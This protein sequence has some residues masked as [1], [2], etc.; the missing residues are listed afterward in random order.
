M[1]YDVYKSLNLLTEPAF[2]VTRDLLYA[3]DTAL[4]S[5]SQ[6]NLQ[7]LVNAVVREGAKYGLELNWEKTFQ[8]N[9]GIAES[10]YRPDGSVL[11]QKDSLIYLGGLIAANSRVSSELN[12]RLSEGRAIFNILRQFWSHVNLS[13]DRKLVVFNACVTSKVMYALDSAWL[14]KVDRSRLDAFQCACL[15]RILKIPHSY[16]SRI[17]NVEVLGRSYQTKF[18]DILQSRQK[19]LYQRIQAMPFNSLMH[20]LVCD[21]V[22]QPK[23]WAFARN[24]GRP[25][26]RWGPCVFRLIS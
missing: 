2:L 4:L 8:M 21:S 1:F 9:V 18:S 10:I 24:R 22:G 6:D 7:N 25:Q 14:V 12:R 3:D 15:R 17:T 23:N 13:I 11:T 16:I 19:R 5:A 20:N 26:Q